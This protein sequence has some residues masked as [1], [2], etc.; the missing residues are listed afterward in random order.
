MKSRILVTGGAGFIGSHLV[1]WLVAREQAVTVLDDFSTGSRGNLLAAMQKGDVR[2]VEG[3]ILDQQA[4]EEAMRDC[5]LVYHLAVQCVRR[6]LGAPLHNHAVNATGTLNV[7]EVARQQ[8]VKR[9]LYCSSSEVYGN[10]STARLTE[11]TLCQPTTVYGAAKLAGEYYTLAYQRTYG[12]PITVVRPFNAYGPREHDQGD[13]AE[14]IPRFV[15]RI[16]NGLPPIIFGNGL[17]GRDFTY[18]TEIAKGI[19]M[20]GLAEATTGRV[21]NMA[22]GQMITIREVARIIAEQIGRADLQPQFVDERPGDVLALHADTGLAKELLAYRAEIAF[23][24]GVG[25]YLH[26]FKESYADPSLLLEES[27]INWQMPPK[28]G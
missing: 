10:S 18:V 23:A 15:I 20:A 4:I 14:V 8:R 2:I 24:E 19:G 25:R 12:L 5:E 21:V 13:L 1:D 16:L 26:W 3:S 6:S 7:L 11:D 27:Y 9:F 22:Y 28:A 17:Q